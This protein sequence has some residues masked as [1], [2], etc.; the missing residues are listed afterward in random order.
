MN[1]LSLHNLLKPRRAD[2]HKGDYGKLLLVCGSMEMPGAAALSA[3]AALRSGV[4]LCT[5]FCERA[6]MPALSPAVPE[7]IFLYPDGP[8]TLEE[9]VARSSAVLVGCGLGK[10]DEA[11]QRL[12]TVLDKAQCPVVVDAD[13]INLV[14]GRIDCIKPTGSVILTP[15]IG[16]MSRLTGLAAGTIK[17]QRKRVAQQLATGHQ[18]TVVL[19]DHITVVAAPDGRL[20]VNDSLGNPGMAKAGSGDTLSG[21]LSALCAGGLPPFEAA[22]A[23]VQL[24]AM[25]GDRAAARLSQTAMLPA[26]MS[27]CLCE[28]FAELGL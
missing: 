26:D 24:H 28:V 1:E 11:A 4:G 19:K 8:Q 9:A 16:E 22:A 20:F 14:C 13:G 23:A 18:V 25:A 5:I 6:L 21:I 3:K 2:T 7:A 27:D 15:H 12:F 17:A 10:S